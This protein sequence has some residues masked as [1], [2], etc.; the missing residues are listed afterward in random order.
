MRNEFHER[1]I[2]FNFPS[3][4]R[5]GIEGRGIKS[6]CINSITIPIFFIDRRDAISCVSTKNL[7]LDCFVVSL[8]EMTMG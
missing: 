7:N 3:T 5:E 6:K 8:L 4:L 2:S 1:E